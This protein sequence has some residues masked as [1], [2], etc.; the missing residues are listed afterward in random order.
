MRG[1]RVVLPALVGLAQLRYVDLVG[2]FGIQPYTCGMRETVYADIVGCSF[3]EFVEFL[4]DREIPEEESFAALWARGETKKWNPW[5]WWT[6]VTFD[7]QQ[8]C[9]YYTRLFRHPRFLLGKFSKEQL[10]DG[11][12]AVQNDGLDCSAHC[13]IWHTELPFASREECVR[14]MFVLFRDLFATES[15][16]TSVYMWW[17]SICYDWHCGNRKRENG[18]EDLTMQDVM[19][20]TL[21]EILALDSAICQAAALHGLSHLHHPSTDAAIQNYLSANPLLS[22]ELN[23]M[24]LHAARFELL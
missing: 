2:R 7:A 12:W 20:E 5:H 13:L 6:E 1:A 23:D 3:E 15:L 10:E 8:V 22:K 4:F 9:L 14:S 17:D 11:F 19:S 16:D 24:A 21:I 18:G